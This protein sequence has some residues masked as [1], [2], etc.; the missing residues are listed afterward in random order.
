MDEVNSNTTTATSV[1]PP[2]S[3]PVGQPDSSKATITIPKEEYERLK[4]QAAEYL[5]GWK[6]A[7]AD[8]LNFKKETDERQSEF[9]KFST[10]LAL[11]GL[12][13]IY[14]HLKVAFAH[15][16]PE[17]KKDPW[18]DGIA[19]I[20]QELSLYL[21]DAGIE[22][23]HALGKLFDPVQHESVGVEV[24]PDKPLHTVVK[25]IKSGYTMHGKVIIPA[26]VIISEH[27]EQLN[28]QTT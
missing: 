12:L 5:D 8:Y 9:V 21:H 17:Q 14:D 23:I 22:E 11:M 24:V 26:Q 13:P 6:R 18:V 20:K 3:L 7:K 1:V 10:Q 19:K 16:T 2:S 25:E 4:A 27:Q 28:T 15:L